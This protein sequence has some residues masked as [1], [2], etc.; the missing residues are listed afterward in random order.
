MK[1]LILAIVL[2]FRFLC[3]VIF[4]LILMLWVLF[5]HIIKQFKIKIK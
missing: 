2:F 5:E 4:T 3:A 1:K